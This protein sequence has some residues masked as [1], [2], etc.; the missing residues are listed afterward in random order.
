MNKAQWAALFK[1]YLFFEVYKNYLQVDIVAADNDDLLAW[2]GWVE[3]RLRQLTLKVR[4]VSTK[5]KR[6]NFGRLKSNSVVGIMIFCFLW[7]IMSMRIVSTK[8]KKKEF[9]REIF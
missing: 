9:W 2:R 4:I 3:S 1:H 6:K 5:G 7:F 8:G